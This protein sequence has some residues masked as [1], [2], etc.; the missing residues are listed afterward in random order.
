MEIELNLLEEPK[1]SYLKKSQFYRNLDSE[2]EE[3]IFILHICPID[4]QNINKFG[5]TLDFWNVD[6]LPICF[7]YLIWKKIKKYLISFEKVEKYLNSN[8]QSVKK[9]T[10]DVI[11]IKFY[12][13]FN[14]LLKKNSLIY[15]DQLFKRYEKF[16]N[17]SLTIFLIYCI[18]KENIEGFELIIRYEKIYFPEMYEN[19]EINRFKELFN[20]CMRKGKYIFF[21]YL[22]E[23]GVEFK[24]LYISSA[25]KKIEN[26]EYQK[27]LKYFVDNVKNLSQWKREYFNRKLKETDPYFFGKGM[28]L[29]RIYESD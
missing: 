19:G 10:K 6:K 28:N 3:K 13:I 4:E 18:K 16:K 23:R 17:N 15:I 21:K 20:Y 14:K 27:C 12:I 22:H 5:Q 7:F 9:A 25:I 26:K 8:I 11:R 1:Y 2:S 24:N 29:L